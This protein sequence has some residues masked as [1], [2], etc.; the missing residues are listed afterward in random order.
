MPGLLKKSQ[1]YIWGL[2]F[3]WLFGCGNLSLPSHSTALN[4]LSEQKEVALRYLPQEQKF[5]QASENTCNASVVASLIRSY[6]NDVTP[7]SSRFDL[8]LKTHFEHCDFQPT[9][10][11][12]TAYFFNTVGG[13]VPL[14]TKKAGWKDAPLEIVERFPAFCDW[15]KQGYT[16]LQIYSETRLK[17][18]TTLKSLIYL[19]DVIPSDREVCYIDSEAAAS[20]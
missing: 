5:P 1:K 12:T 7:D 11:E 6:S 14:K 20:Y 17:N 19:W 2:P 8:L 16:Q 4:A 13:P 9:E 15:Y 3:L 10:V 18:G